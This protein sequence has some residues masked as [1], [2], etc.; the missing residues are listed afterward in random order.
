M[1][2]KTKYIIMFVILAFI[3]SLC[4]TIYSF[5]NNI[6]KNKSSSI[7]TKEKVLIS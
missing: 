6:D 1:K 4:F 5:A 2:N 7:L 3:I